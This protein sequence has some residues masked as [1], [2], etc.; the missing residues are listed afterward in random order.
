MSHIGVILYQVMPAGAAL[1]LLAAFR[2]PS[3]HRINLALV[4]CSLGFSLYAG[5]LILALSSSMSAPSETLWGD[6]HFK[7]S[8]R[9]EIMALA[10]AF[11]T[12]FDSRSRLDVIRELR[13]QDIAAVPSIAP[14]TLLNEQGRGTEVSEIRIGGQEILP[15]GG[16]S[17]SVAVL[18]NETG[19]YAIYESDERGFHNPRGIWGSRSMAI[20]AVG[21]SFTEGSCV[22]SDRNFMALIRNRYPE[23]L[24]LGMSGEGPLLMFAAI[25]EYLSIVKPKVVL[26]FFYEGNDF[27]DLSKESKTGL[28]RQYIEGK[29]KQGLFDRQPEIDQA[30]TRYVEGEMTRELAERGEGPQDDAKDRLYYP[31]TLVQFLKVRHVRGKLGLVY[32][33]A[34]QDSKDWYSQGQFDLFRTV[35]L[36]AKRSVEEWGGTLYI[37]YLPAR[38]RYANAQDYHRQAVLDVVEKIGLPIVD[39]HAAY[40]DESDPMK[41][42]PF[43]RFGHYNEEGNRIVA[44]EVLKVISK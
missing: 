5:E 13:R 38:D 36:Q 26:W 25:T 10:K 34:A 35:L 15:L 41:F 23:T 21:D 17:N 20:A 9:K 16:I 39:V 27:A 14:I 37:V 18:C 24:N 6:A 3:A 1:L 4:L 19:R 30:L 42:F 33:R 43:R 7:E 2:L 12:E 32:G 11:N 44:G 31:Q 40:Q 28:L 29:F 8:E 22:P